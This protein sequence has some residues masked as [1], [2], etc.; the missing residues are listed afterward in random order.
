MGTKRDYYEVLGI[1]RG[2]DEGEIKSAYRKLV[3]LYHPDATRDD[4]G[5]EDK[6]K[7]I[8]EAYDVL[9][10]PQKKADYDQ[11]GHSVPDRGSSARSGGGS[12]SGG[13]GGSA[14]INIDDMFTGGFGSYFRSGGKRNDPERG[15]NITADVHI[16]YDESKY[17]TEKELT[18][19]YSEKC[20]SCNGSGSLS[21]VTPG[22]CSKCNGTGHERTVTQS[23]F[24][25]MTQTR[26]CTVCRGTGKDMSASCSK[27]F[28]RGYLKSSKRI[29]VKI[30]RGVVNGHTIRIKDLGEPGQLP[31]SRGDL[32]VN[33]LVR[34]KLGF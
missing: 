20:G 22:I 16:S 12:S 14:D 28:G 15:R 3:K 5:A 32:I 24:G 25:K 30:P 26:E 17:G 33:V 21:G 13:F 7:E 2:A 10:D 19:N 9:S 29:K 6:I 27:C 8:N 4:E 18:I 1:K 23:A 34:P 11:F 31:G